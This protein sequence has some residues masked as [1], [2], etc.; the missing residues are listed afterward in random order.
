MYYVY[1]INLNN[2]LGTHYVFMYVS[3]FRNKNYYY[4]IN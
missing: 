3:I 4:N 1:H 2:Y